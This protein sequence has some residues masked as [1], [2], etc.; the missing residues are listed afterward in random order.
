M[1]RTNTDIRD[2]DKLSLSIRRTGLDKINT[3]GQLWKKWALAAWL[4]LAAQA[5]WLIAEA[6]N[7]RM[8]SLKKLITDSKSIRRQVHR[9]KRSPKTGFSAGSGAA[10][11]PP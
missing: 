4:R 3:T 9:A 11:L 5:E 7:E 2:N 10:P 1:S 8:H 6:L